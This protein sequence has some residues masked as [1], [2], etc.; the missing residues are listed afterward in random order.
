MPY[1]PQ[2]DLTYQ[3]INDTFPQILQ[4]DG[5]GNFYDGTGNPVSVG[6]GTGAGSTGPT[7]P[8]G[9]TGDQGSQGITGPTGPQGLTGPTG[10]TGSAGVNGI[11]SGLVYYYDGPSA[12]Q[13]VPIASLITDDLLLFPNIGAQT[14]I[15]TTSF[16]PSDG[17]TKI[18]QYVT[19]AIP[20]DTVIIIPGLWVSNLFAQRTAGIGNLVYWIVI[21]EMASDGTTFIANIASGNSASGTPITNVQNNYIYTQFVSSYT[22]ASVNSRIRVSIYANTTG[23]NTAFTIEMRDSTLSN[24]VTTLS[25]NIAGPTGPQG[26]TGPTGPTGPIGVT[27]PTGANFRYSVTGPTAPVGPLIGDRWYDTTQGTEFVY[28]NDG[29]SSQWVTPVVAPQGP[30]GPQGPAGPSLY[31][32]IA[33]VD[34]LKSSSGFYQATSG[35]N[36]TMPTPDLDGIFAIIVDSGS[37]SLSP[38]SIDATV[39][40]TLQITADWGSL[41]LLSVGGNWIPISQYP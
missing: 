23:V 24:V 7:G 30:T 17:D 2:F 35:D 6:G 37:A 22:L 3:L 10:A 39:L 33:S 38:V 28:I 11:S 21:D 13:T 34:D 26:V 29:D 31:S 41:T 16:S 19:P 14:T 5:A 25:A 36:L 40:G 1:N 32:Q 20:L 9:P 8:T 15:V 18:V 4:T 27:G 12:S